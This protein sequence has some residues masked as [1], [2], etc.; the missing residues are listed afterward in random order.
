MQRV[1]L[2]DEV[3]RDDCV[4]MC[5]AAISVM[6]LELAYC[7]NTVTAGVANCVSFEMCSVF[8]QVFNNACNTNVSCFFTVCVLILLSMTDNNYNNDRPRCSGAV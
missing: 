7:C 2:S 3:S 1:P 4:R 5:V 8:K 6:S